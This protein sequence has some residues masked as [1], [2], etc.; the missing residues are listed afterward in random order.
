[1]AEIPG[2]YTTEGGA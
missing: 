1:V 2:K